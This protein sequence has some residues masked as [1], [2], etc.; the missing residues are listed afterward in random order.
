MR[1]NIQFSIAL[2]LAL[3][4]ATVYAQGADSILNMSDQDNI[5]DPNAPVE[6]IEERYDDGRVKVRR[7][8]T[9]D[10]SGNYIKHG[11]W[12][13]FSITEE[14]SASGQFENNE[15]QGT[16]TRTLNWG[17][18]DLLNDLPYTEFEAP[19]ISQAEFKDGDLH[20]IWTITDA[21]GRTASEWTY[22]GGKLDGVAKWYYPDGTLREEITYSKGLIDGSYK[23]WDQDGTELTN[24]TYQEGRKLAVKQ[25]LYPSGVVKWEGMFLH[26]TYVVKSDDDWWTTR[27]V[28]YEKTGKP[29]RHG[30][31]TSWYENGQKKFEGMF[32]HEIKS[33]EFTWWH[34]N[35]QRAVQ[36]SF[37]TDERH[38]LWS[39]WHENGQ[40]AIQGQYENGK[41][42]G[43]W[44]YWNADGKLERKMDYTEEAE[45]IAVNT[46]VPVPSTD[47]PMVAD[48]RA[49]EATK[50]V[51]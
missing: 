5:A 48:Q 10:M 16:W 46:V 14:E 19:F 8:V 3:A 33:G 2:V 4:G 24:D 50:T 36:G 34:E 51:K 43:K 39:W 32:E 42:A 18:A 47:I 35:T 7:E 11:M 28:T 12:K 25:D 26:E 37:K 20:G 22:A 17:E 38:G 29:E 44:S 21:Q 15:R 6:V 9:L 1:T 13:S 27:P 49:A 41:L 31:F 30:R 45:P 23:L 40:K